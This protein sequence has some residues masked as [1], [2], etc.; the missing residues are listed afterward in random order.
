MGHEWLDNLEPH[1]QH[2][3]ALKTKAKSFKTWA[4]E[5]QDFFQ[6]AWAS[7]LYNVGVK[8]KP[9]VG[10]LLWIGIVFLALKM[11]YL[12]VSDLNNNPPTLESWQS[13][14]GTTHLFFFEVIHYS[15]FA[16]GVANND[17]TY[18][19]LVQLTYRVCS[20]LF[21]EG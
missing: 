3:V 1:P 21:K 17:I 15:F 7:M 11:V 19:A 10:M 14:R 8:V 13:L 6:I 18:N 9:N 12:M 20:M 2:L 4:L 5:N 16:G